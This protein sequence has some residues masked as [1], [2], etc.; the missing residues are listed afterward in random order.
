ML[1][2]LVTAPLDPLASL[3]MNALSRKYEYEAGEFV[4]RLFDKR[5]LTL[6]YPDEF[7]ADLNKGPE[8]SRALI[9]IMNENLAS[10]HN[11]WLYSMYKHSHPTL[12]ERLSRLNE[13]EEK[14]GH[15]KAVEAKKEL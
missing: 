5:K 10:P 8:L 9:K 12:V 14:K 7:A 2:Q 3:G 6:P 4:V 1:F 11:D 15:G 13:Y